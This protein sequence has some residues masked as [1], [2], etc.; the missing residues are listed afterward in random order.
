MAKK[1]DISTYRNIGISAHIDS[2]KTTLTERILFYTGL[3][4]KISE[5]RGEGDGAKMDHMELEKE[6]GI[7]I[8]SAAVTTQWND[9]LIQIIDTPGHV[10]FTVEVER[11]LRVLDGAI[12]VLCGA[13]GVQSQ[14]ITVDRQMRRYKV[15]CMAFINKLDRA[16]ASA[17]KVTGQLRDK[18]NHNAVMMQIQIGEEG[19]FDGVVDLFKRKAYYFDGEKGTEIR[20][21][22]VPADLVDQM[23]EYR[24]NMMDSVAMFNDDMMEL[25]LEEKEVPEEMFNETLRKAV[26]AR[27]ITPVFMGSAFKNKG[28]QLLL[29]AVVK[30]LPSPLDMQYWGNDVE[31][32]EK[33]QVF[34]DAKKPLCAMAFKIT[35]E[36]YG[37]LTY[38]R[39]YQGVLNKGDTPYN[40]R[41]GKTQRVGRIVQMFSNDK[42]ELQSARAGDIIAMV[43]VDCA[44]GD[45]YCQS[46][47]GA[48]TM[49]AMH[50]QN[51]V[52]ELALKPAKQDDLP[53]ISKA[54]NRFMKEDPTFQVSVDPESNE[55]IIK[56]MGELHLEIYVQ[57]IERE[58]KA[59]VIVGAPKV[60]YR[61]APTLAADF[62]YK[63]KKQSGGSGQYGH[64]V[65]QLKPLVLDESGDDDQENI[66]INNN[67]VGG[68]IP[69][70]YIP[71]IEKGFRESMDKG[72][73]AGYQVLGAELDINDGTYHP[74]DSSEM[75]F[76]IAARN[77][78][79]EAF[80][81]SKPVILE[82]VMKVEVETPTEFQ[83][84]VQG[85]LSSR[86]G[87][88]S[89]SDMREDLTIIECEVPLSE[90]FGYSTELRSMTQGKAGFSMEFSKYKP[91]PNSIQEQLVAK[92]KEERAKGNKG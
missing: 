51:P 68:A 86:R 45:T 9:H 70:E 89:G 79:K 34:A 1:F 77:A 71:G 73:L 47:E 17:V 7:T 36:T 4:H 14:S 82:P 24:A 60:N 22:E 21:E 23:E 31:S 29:D 91:V 44:S 74:V 66:K 41:L 19:D 80:L 61:E 27:E 52:I 16:G 26:I 43:G 81:A 75:A 69:K 30:Y 38:T 84:T 54:L 63:H 67:I 40:P 49:E 35:D 37:Q 65:G 20:E 88:L 78:F 83:G 56:G 76:K 39:I 46:E 59:N 33:V 11:S 32:G 3:I 48:L 25:V 92:Y 90:M 64:V 8:T 72:P 12:L 28:V 10:D 57:R 2:G 55:T 62:D 15:P 58:Y 13:S 85:D 53:K 18:L 42:I 5:V 50:V 87:I 6:R